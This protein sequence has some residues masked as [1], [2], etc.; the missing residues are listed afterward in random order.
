MINLDLVK[1]VGDINS[2]NVFIQL[3]DDHDMELIESEG[4]AL[5][6]LA[7]HDDWCI[8]A[9]PVTD[10][11]SDLTPWKSEPVFGKQPFGDGAEKTL[12][13]LVEEYVDIK[14]K[15]LYLCGY[16]LAGL[17]ALWSAYQT[18][19]FSGIVAASP[20]MWY[21]DFLDY[22]SAHDIKVGKVYLSIG[23]KEEKAKNKVMATVGD[24]IR[25]QYELLYTA[26][27]KTCLE[28]NKGNHFVDSDIRT[29][30][31]M[32]WML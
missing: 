22:T 25:R 4:D 28:Y 5:R 32:A 11:F 20:S 15:D 17:F 6:K 26:G 18:D 8:I 10:W 13:I 3:V 24:C 16:S 27:V 29:A 9:I 1:K 31:G 12:K 2:R 7:G 23:E 19:I 14:D 21:K 30:K